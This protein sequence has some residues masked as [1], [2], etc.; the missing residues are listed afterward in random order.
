M[1]SP[2]EQILIALQELDSMLKEAED[3]Q[4]QFSRLGFGVSG[5]DELRKARTLLVGQL[6]PNNVQHYERMVVRYGRAVTPVT[7]Q[8]CLGCFAAVPSVYRSASY[9]GRVRM[10]QNCGRILYFP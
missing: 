1:I 5:V 3:S 2:Q 6:E 8:M 9:E 4:E 7:G 10:C